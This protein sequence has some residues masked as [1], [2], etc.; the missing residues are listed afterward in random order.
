MLS[1]RS[2]PA[3]YYGM[4]GWER[5]PMIDFSANREENLFI[6]IIIYIGVTPAYFRWLARDKL[7]YY[8]T[9]SMINGTVLSIDIH[10][11]TDDLYFT[12]N[13]LDADGD[14]TTFTARSIVLGTGMKDLL[15]NTP[16]LQEAWGKG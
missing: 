5:I 9:V 8:D 4:E 12:A 11:T 16:G 2:K 15:P 10:N 6:I 13:I 3:Y 1:V 14:P 7:S